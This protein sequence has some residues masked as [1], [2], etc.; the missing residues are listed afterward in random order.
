MALRKL[1]HAPKLLTR[2]LDL[3]CAGQ[4]APPKWLEGLRPAVVLDWGGE[5]KNSGKRAQGG[6]VPPIRFP[7]DGLV[8]AYYDRHPEARMQPVD[9]RS[10]T[11]PPARE[12]AQR[13]LQLMQAESISAKVAYHRLKAEM[14]ADSKSYPQQRRSVLAAVQE[15]E[16]QVL[17]DAMRTLR[18]SQGTLRVAS[19]LPDGPPGSG[20]P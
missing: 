10:F 7:E 2:V 8:R 1:K 11:P 5:R 19:G 4:M 12:F 6:K 9:L 13:Q 16:E 14:L 3:V 15:E 20:P 18:E 17:Q